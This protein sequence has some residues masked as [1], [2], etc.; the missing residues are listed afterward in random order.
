MMHTQAA[1][2]VMVG[3]F[4]MSGFS[5]FHTLMTCVNTLDIAYWQLEKTNN[6]SCFEYALHTALHSY[7]LVL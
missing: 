3:A 1:C 4:L 6:C 5:A 2:S 7:F